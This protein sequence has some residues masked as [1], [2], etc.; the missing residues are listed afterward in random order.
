MRTVLAICFLFIISACIHKEA[1]TERAP[2]QALGPAANI[3]PEDLTIWSLQEMAKK[4]KFAELNDLFNNHGL[5]LTALPQGYAA[6]AATRI[7][8]SEGPRGEGSES[9]TG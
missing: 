2:A 1:T 6:G 5:M 9:I 3:K 4:E 8:G 7:F